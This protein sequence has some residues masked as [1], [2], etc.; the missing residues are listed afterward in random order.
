MENNN[1]STS[2]GSQAKKGLSTFVLTLSISLIVFSAIY[3]FMTSNADVSGENDLN[4]S[5]V[6]VY[7]EKN[8]DGEEKT[9]F[10]EIASVDPN[11]TSR[12]VLAGTDAEVLEEIPVRQTTSSNTAP[13]TGITSI[14]IGLFSALTL[15]ISAIIFV[16]KGPRKFALN[17]FEKRTTKGL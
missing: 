15:F 1:T 6:S 17:S 14:T 16:Y 8:A 10:G 3:Y 11:T 4:P 7:Q 5:A 13:E 12:Q 9:V 2:L